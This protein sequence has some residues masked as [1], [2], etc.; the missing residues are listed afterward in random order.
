[1][2]YLLINVYVSLPIFVH[3]EMFEYTTHIKL[4]SNRIDLFKISS[5]LLYSARFLHGH[6][7]SKLVKHMRWS[8][9]VVKAPLKIS[10]TDMNLRRHFFGCAKYDEK[11]VSYI[12]LMLGYFPLYKV[13]KYMIS[14][15]TLGLPICK[16]LGTAVIFGCLIFA[17][18]LVG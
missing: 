13:E 14:V 16:R 10:W 11:S 8:T 6:P 2:I 1:M 9:A 18:T 4:F 15:W 12:K 7:H 5:F 3:W 17:L